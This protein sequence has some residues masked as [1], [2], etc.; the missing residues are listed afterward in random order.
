MRNLFFILF[1]LIFVSCKEDV[2]PKPKAYLSLKYPAKSYK[3]LH[4][5]RPYVF[6]VEKNATVK[7]SKNNWLTIKYPNL[8]ATIDI[9]YR[10]IKNNLKELL[11]ESEKLVFKHTVKAE[12]IVSNDFINESEKV[13][14]SIYEITGNA[15]SQIQFHATDSTEHFI[16]GALYFYTQPNYDSI[17]PAVDFVKKDIVRIMETLRWKD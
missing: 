13:F 11:I 8:K 2:L 16:K 17:L 4:F 12:Q 7:D 1:I 14:G 15:A 9:T 3:K 5:E 6:D 10:P